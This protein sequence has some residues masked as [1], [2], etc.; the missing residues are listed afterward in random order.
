MKSESASASQE[1]RIGVEFLTLNF[2]K[3][4]GNFVSAQA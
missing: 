4:R 2:S 1:C 3:Q